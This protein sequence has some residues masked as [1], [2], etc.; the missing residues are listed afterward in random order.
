VKSDTIKR[1]YF[2]FE[3]NEVYSGSQDDGG[4]LLAFVDQGLLIDRRPI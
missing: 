1:F 3:E 2:V 4:C